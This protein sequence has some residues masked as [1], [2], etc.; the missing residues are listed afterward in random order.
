MRFKCKAWDKE[1]KR[2]FR[3]VRL[4]WQQWWVQCERPLDAP[5]ENGNAFYGDRNSFSNE[6]TDRHILRW[7]IGGKD[8]T[9]IEL[10]DGDIVQDNDGH[11]YEI[12]WKDNAWN[13]LRKIIQFSEG[14]PY[15]QYFYIPVHIDKS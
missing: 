15:T 9:G 13:Y 11:I 8:K 12:L 6:E 14:Q 5:A 10:Y 3:V 7:Y 1:L 4:D 2:M